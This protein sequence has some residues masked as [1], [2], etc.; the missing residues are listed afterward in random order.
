MTYA[1]LI[2]EL[3]KL[4]KEQLEDDVLIELGL[5]GKAILDA[6]LKFCTDLHEFL[7]EN[8]PVIWIAV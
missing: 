3:Q 8:Y 1:E 5:S 2:K 4:T 7:P 6:E